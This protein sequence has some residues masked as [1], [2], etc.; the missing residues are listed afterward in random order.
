MRWQH[1][2][3]AIQNRVCLNI[4]LVENC[5]ERQWNLRAAEF[6]E[7]RNRTNVHCV[8][9]RL[10]SHDSYILT[11]D[12]TWERNRTS[13]QC[14]RRVSADP[15]LCT[16]MNAMF[17]ATKGHI[18]VL[19]VESS[20]RLSMNWSL[21]F[22]FTPMLSRTHVSTAE[23]VSE[24]LANSRNIC[25]SHTMKAPGSR[26]TFVRRSSAREV[27]LSHIYF[28]MK[29][30]GHTFAVNVQSVFVLQLNWNVIIWHI[31]TW[32]SF[33][34]AYVINVLNIDITL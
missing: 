3:G 21:T 13:V 25:W 29:T 24:G 28:D 15:P 31:Q 10:V 22:V 6:A 27:T 16:T 7:K 18:S 1:T 20:L 4:L 5:S 26:V 19:S 30:W 12:C 34:V 2:R 17:T 23:N 32:N 11:W 9:R 33:A 8:T 14:V